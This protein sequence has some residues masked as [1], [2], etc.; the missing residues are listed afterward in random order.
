M[1]EENEQDPKLEERK[2]GAKGSADAPHPNAGESVCTNYLRS[3]SRFNRSPMTP[4]AER[5]ESFSF[6]L[7][8]KVKRK[9]EGKRQKERP[10][11]QVEHVRRL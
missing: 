6:S 5:D 2:L 1:L 8:V 3:A 4:S 11:R 7:G 10:D 9:G